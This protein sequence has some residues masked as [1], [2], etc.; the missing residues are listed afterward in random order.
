MRGKVRAVHAH[1]RTPTDDECE[2]N[3]KDKH[4]FGTEGAQLRESW[5]EFLRRRP[6]LI[7]RAGRPV[8]VVAFWSCGV[9]LV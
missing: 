3:D 6:L 2:R 1:V 4:S 5:R 8:R 7:V 9:N